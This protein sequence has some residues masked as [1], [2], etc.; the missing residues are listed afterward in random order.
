MRA[1]PVS[2]AGRIR[3]LVRVIR[4]GDEALVED[5]VLRLSRSRRWLAPLAL[6][7]GAF[8]MLFEGLK[9]VLLNWRL[10]LI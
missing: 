5:A 6:A 7:I 4:D 9:L 2:P 1:P 10:A 3:E 8:E